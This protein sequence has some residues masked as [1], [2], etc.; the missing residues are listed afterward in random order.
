MGQEWGHRGASSTPS[1][2]AVLSMQPS[3]TVT[4]VASTIQL[5]GRE[6]TKGES[7][8]LSFGVLTSC[9]ERE[10]SLLCLIGP[11]YVVGL[12]PA[13]GRWGRPACFLISPAEKGR[14]R[15]V[16]VERTSVSGWGVVPE[17]KQIL[18]S[19]RFLKFLYF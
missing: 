17:R 2:S 15:V 10:T 3:S 8:T 11:G 12:L 13:A 1:R 7:K 9:S 6:R 18:S 4:V 14:R 16:G 5:E 19:Y